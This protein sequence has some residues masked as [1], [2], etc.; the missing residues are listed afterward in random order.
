M[1]YSL[2]VVLVFHLNISFSY[3]VKMVE[4]WGLDLVHLKKAFL[5]LIE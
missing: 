4:L 3:V 5:V 1:Q 2:V